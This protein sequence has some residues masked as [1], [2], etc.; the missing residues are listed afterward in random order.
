MDN[1]EPL[2]D[3]A[4][5]L[6]A[7]NTFSEAS[8][9]LERSYNE[10]QRHTQDLDLELASTNERLRTSL[11]EQETTS[12]HLKSILNTLNTGILVID[13][14]GTVLEF[15]PR[16]AQLLGVTQE[17]VHYSQLQL[18]EP[19]A[20]FLYSCIESTMPRV[21][22][23][24]V[25]VVRNGE[26]ADLELTFSLVR[27]QGGGILSVLILIEDKTL[28]K[29]LQGQSRRNE[30]LA[31]MG[32][33]AAELAHEIRNPLGSIKLFASLL[34]GDL[35]EMPDKA[36]LAGQISRGVLTLEN[37]VSNILTFSANVRP[38]RT[39][40]VLSH[41]IHESLP[42]FEMERSRKQITLDINNP[43]PDPE[44]LGDPQ[45]LKQAL[46][47]LANNAIKAMEPGGTLTIH[48]R[49]RAEFAEIEITD[50]GRGIPPELLPK[51]FDPFVTTFQ[52]GTG[53]GLSVVN[54]IIDKHDGAIDVKSTLNVGT[55]VFLSL[56]RLPGKQHH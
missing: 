56:P 52:G 15:N 2:T 28:L 17:R 24:E 22:C 3:Q 23:K 34:E 9:H 25:A 13:L 39:P 8:L 38:V 35:V 51:I 12:L 54:Q 42:L 30:R 40:I 7:F 11:L 5:L 29:R 45:L 55:S 41:L 20:E 21:P 33:M 19:V 1:S 16:A 36:E 37:I 18:P 10:L 27:P 49:A 32:E 26:I 14:E 53:L 48:V 50:T 44:I 6:Q 31:A 4:L 43:E 47:N 46:L